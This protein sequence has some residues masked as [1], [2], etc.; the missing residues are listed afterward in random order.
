MLSI[1]CFGW[2]VEHDAPACVRCHRH[3]E[4]STLIVMSWTSKGVEALAASMRSAF[5]SVVLTLL[6]RGFVQ[7]P[8]I[9]RYST[10]LSTSRPHHT[11]FRRRGLA[12]TT[13]KTATLQVPTSNIPLALASCLNLTMRCGACAYLAGP[14]SHSLIPHINKRHCSFPSVICRQSVLC[15]QCLS[16]FICIAA[17]SSYM[18]HLSV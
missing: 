13:Q 17:L 10:R 14:C 6:L 8:H 18:V 15:A 5:E 7:L 16:T 1:G 12:S 2:D 4:I 3:T 9:T 11:P